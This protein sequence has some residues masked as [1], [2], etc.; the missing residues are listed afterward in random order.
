MLIHVAYIP[1]LLQED[2]RCRNTLEF[3]IICHT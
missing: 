3:A 1:M 2:E